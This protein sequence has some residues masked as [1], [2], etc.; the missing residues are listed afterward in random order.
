MASRVAS[1]PRIN[2]RCPHCGCTSDR[3]APGKF[4]CRVR[5]CRKDFT[6]ADP[7]FS[8]A[9]GG[10]RMQIFDLAT[11]ALTKGTPTPWP[12]CPRCNGSSDKLEDG[13]FKC[14]VAGCREVFGGSLPN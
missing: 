5:E 1:D 11:P 9:P 12:R 13:K 14:R 2:P 4:K 7:N 3:L 8:R 10:D 6:A